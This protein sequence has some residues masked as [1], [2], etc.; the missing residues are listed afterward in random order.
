MAFVLPPCMAE[1]VTVAK[2]AAKSATLS[3]ISGTLTAARRTPYT[4]GEIRP[5]YGGATVPRP[6]GIARNDRVRQPC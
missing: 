6:S 5:Q 2:L 1:T 3:N 4:T